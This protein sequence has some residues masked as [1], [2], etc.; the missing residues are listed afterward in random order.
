MNKY[1][2]ISSL[3]YMNNNILIIILLFIINLSLNLYKIYDNRKLLTVNI[4]DNKII[5]IYSS[6]IVILLSAI[7]YI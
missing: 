7:L 6:L 4:N 1:K 3:K 5:L 2:F